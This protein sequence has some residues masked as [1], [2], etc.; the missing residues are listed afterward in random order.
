MTM[1]TD[2]GADMDANMDTD[3]NATQTFR[4]KYFEAKVFLID[5]Q[6]EANNQ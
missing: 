3:K 2:M 5:S 6:T 4:I 1:N